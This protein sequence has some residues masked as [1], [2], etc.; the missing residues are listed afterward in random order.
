MDDIDLHRMDDDGAPH[1]PHDEEQEPLID[2]AGAGLRAAE[3]TL[4]SLLIGAHLLQRAMNS[5]LSAELE[6]K[7][8]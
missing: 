8:Q 6:V 1:P 7:A 4:R 2:R 5:H 3:N